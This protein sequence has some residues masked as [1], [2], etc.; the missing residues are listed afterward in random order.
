[1]LGSVLLL[2]PGVG[3]AHAQLPPHLGPSI[4]PGMVTALE[5]AGFTGPA[6]LEAWE[7][8]VI[9][10]ARWTGFIRWGAG[11]RM[12]VSAE[13]IAVALQRSNILRQAVYTIL[14]E[15]VAAGF[16]GPTLLARLSG[17][18][19]WIRLSMHLVPGTIVTRV[20]LL[21][22][23]AVLMMIVVT[24]AVAGTV[25]YVGSSIYISKLDMEAKAAEDDAYQETM[26]RIEKG[27]GTGSVKLL[28][29]ITLDQALGKIRDNLDA[30]LPP[31]AGVLEPRRPPDI[32]GGW[33]GD[34]VVK[35]VQG[36]SNIPIGQRRRVT[37]EQFR[38]EQDATELTLTFGGNRI[39]GRFESTDFLETRVGTRTLTVV[40]NATLREP[41]GGTVRRVAFKFYSGAGAGGLANKLEVELEQQS[42]G[43]TITSGGQL[44]R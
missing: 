5:Q 27:L 28:S 36:S 20:S 16:T 34:L 43:G 18:Q 13:Q 15:Q 26:D 25:G 32:S 17:H 9:G 10:I 21:R 23:F 24:A 33:Q 30:G 8:L 4:A 6:V 31:Y 19:M 37:P 44:V 11:T 38:I 39:K 41:I 35:D 1:M 7:A 40:D 12:L 29:G 22:V 42:A 14:R 3:Q 2:G